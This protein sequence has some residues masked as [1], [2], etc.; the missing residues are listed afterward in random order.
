LESKSDKADWNERKKKI[1]ELHDMRPS[2]TTWDPARAM[3]PAILEVS[4]LIPNWKEVFEMEANDQISDEGNEE[5]LRSAYCK[6]VGELW[7]E[8]I[9]SKEF[10][11]RQF[12]KWM[13]EDSASET[14]AEI[15]RENGQPDYW[16]TYS[17]HRS[18]YEAHLWNHRQE[19]V[20]RRPIA[21]N[22]SLDISQEWSEEAEESWN[23]DDS[24]LKLPA[25]NTTVD[26]TVG[27]DTIASYDVSEEVAPFNEEEFETL[28]RR[29]HL[30]EWCG[31]YLGD[32][33]TIFS[34]IEQQDDFEDNE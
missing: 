34:D 19:R 25:Q 3:V 9:S 22:T 4:Y 21:S 15:A 16:N 13:A 2:I 8:G 7:Q 32:E 31:D 29:Y 28:W 27:N 20:A 11:Q 12:D 5:E 17:A 33:L 24:N 1:V 10:Q 6:A 14:T 23:E 30:M 26:L 18:K